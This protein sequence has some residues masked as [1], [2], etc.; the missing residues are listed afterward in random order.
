MIKHRDYW[1][2][3][4][5]E[6]QPTIAPD[7]GPKTGLER[8]EWEQRGQALPARPCWLCIT[9]PEYNPRPQ[10]GAE[11]WTIDQII[12]QEEKEIAKELRAKAYAEKHEKQLAE[13]RAKRKVITDAQK[14]Y[15][16]ERAKTNKDKGFSR[17][18]KGAGEPHYAIIEVA[19]D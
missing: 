3:A 19:G 7:D 17:G 14:K 12:A 13:K 9:A 2:N 15:R 6:P 18:R 11:D 5:R 1:G 10:S 16:E 8:R 4:E